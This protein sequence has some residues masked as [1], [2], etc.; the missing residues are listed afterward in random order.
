MGDYVLYLLP[1]C[2]SDSG[3]LHFVSLEM[4]E[5]R[6]MASEKRGQYSPAYETWNFI[7]VTVWNVTI[8]LHR[9]V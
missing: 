4:D 6:M 3:I 1:P 8:L 9:I 5:F 7:F 2:A